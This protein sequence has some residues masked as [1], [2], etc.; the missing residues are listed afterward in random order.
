[1]SFI[2]LAAI[3]LEYYLCLYT[4]RVHQ[5]SRSCTQMKCVKAQFQACIQPG[6]IVHVLMP[7]RQTQTQNPRS[8]VGQNYPC[9]FNVCHVKKPSKTADPTNPFPFW[10]RFRLMY[11]KYRDKRTVPQMQFQFIPFFY[12]TSI[13]YYYS[14]IFL[15][16]WGI[17]ATLIFW[18]RM[19]STA[20]KRGYLS[21]TPRAFRK[22]QTSLVVEMP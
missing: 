11:H 18:S 8:R 15:N 6:R 16:N 5:R 1:M 4:V 7:C 20:M 14:Y 22:L 13:S 17:S 9:A 10:P 19:P 3:N 21:C 12:P 2:L